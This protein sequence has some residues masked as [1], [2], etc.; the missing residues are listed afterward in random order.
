M[1]ATHPGTLIKAVSAY[2]LLVGILCAVLAVIA[3]TTGGTVFFG[4]FGFVGI[5][6]GIS[7]FLY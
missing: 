2:M 1:K 3:P 4:A 6:T 7:G 5:T